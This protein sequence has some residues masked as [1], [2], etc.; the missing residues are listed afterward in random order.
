MMWTENI[1][2]L[3]FW[4]SFVFLV[5]V[6]LGYPLVLAFLT[7]FKKRAGAPEL[8]SRQKVTLL[9]SAFNEQDVIATK[10]DNALQLNYP[11]QLL[12]I[13]VVSDSSSDATDEIV[14]RYEPRGVLLVRQPSR[15]GKSAGLN[16]GMSHATGDIVV[17]SDAN[18]IYQNDAIRH[19]VKHFSNT[20]VGYVVGNARYVEKVS[21]TQ[22]AQAEGLYWKLETWLKKRESLFHSVIGG[23]GA[24]YAIRSALYSPLEPTDIS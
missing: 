10:L 1:V 8:A 18:A 11:Q 15:L 3:I 13:I 12:Q 4:L 5:Y 23:D 9:I 2:R 24:I 17:F 21:D 22:S 6:Y 7:S 19:L 20:R 16:L 14:S